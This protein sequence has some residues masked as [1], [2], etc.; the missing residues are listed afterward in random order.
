MQSVLNG[1]RAELALLER[2]VAPLEKVQLPFPRM[3]YSE[4]VDLLRSPATH[5]RWM[6]EMEGDRAALA[7]KN[8]ELATLEQQRAAAT[9]QWQK[10]KLEA[11]ST[12]LRDDIRERQTELENRPAHIEG[13]RRFEWGGDLGGDEE[14]LLTRMFD[15]PIIV[16]RYPKGVK[17]FYM[18]PDPDDLAKI[19]QKIDKGLDSTGQAAPVRK[20][21]DEKQGG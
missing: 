12:A 21:E 7:A 3:T 8:E 11:Q 5:E 14:T 19:V 10:D 9:K 2:N 17:A 4:A 15:R 1:H 13:A 18:K 20:A 16:S 6:R